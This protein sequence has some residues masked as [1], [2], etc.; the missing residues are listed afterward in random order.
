MNNISR[1]ITSGKNESITPG[2]YRIRKIELSNHLGLILDIQNIVVKTVITESIYSNTL[3]CSITVRDESNL[4]QDFPL[5]GQEKVSIRMT[6]RHGN[7]EQEINLLFYITEYPVYGRAKNERVQAWSF[8]GISEHA[9]LSRFKKISRSVTG[10]TSNAIQNIFTS[11]LKSDKLVIT[12]PPITSFQ[13]IIN[14]QT[15]LSA[16]EWLR[17]K[18]HDINQAPY[19]LFE[20]LQGKVQL[21]SHTDLV[22]QTPYFDYIDGREFNYTPNTKDDYLQQKHRILDI[23]SDL[24]MGKVFQAM[25]GAYASENFYLDIGNKTFTSTQFSYNLE[26]TSLGKKSPISSA[27]TIDDEPINVKY[28]SHY[29]HVSTNAFSFDGTQKNYNELKKNSGGITQAFVENL[30]TT[31]H[32]IRLFGDF[33]LNAG[34]V[35]EIKI[36]KAIDPVVQAKVLN[37]EKYGELDDHISGNYLITSAIHTFE[38]GDYFTSLKIKRDSFTIDL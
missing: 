34:V 36:P 17:K 28:E 3:I 30:E 27:F 23:S 29:E 6:S 9:Y 15:P 22:A 26:A 38:D 24:K 18:T 37:T 13:G 12:S 4:M 11:D 21:V 20:T 2:A 35:I 14:T 1:N 10:L 7:D 19:Y 31:T 8:S 25:D 33:S 5:I 32:D 16:T